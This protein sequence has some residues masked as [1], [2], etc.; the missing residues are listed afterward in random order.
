MLVRDTA[1]VIATDPKPCESFY[2]IK[3]RVDREDGRCGVWF[4]SS[5]QERNETPWGGGGIF[6]KRKFDSGNVYAIP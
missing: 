3:I 5:Y 6:L 1:V 2:L 4:Q